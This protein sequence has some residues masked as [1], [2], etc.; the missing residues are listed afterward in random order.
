M[1]LFGCTIHRCVVD[2]VSI[3]KLTLTSIYIIHIF[4]TKCFVDLGYN[5]VSLIKKYRSQ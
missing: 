1:Q 2:E 4:L 5:R 3:L